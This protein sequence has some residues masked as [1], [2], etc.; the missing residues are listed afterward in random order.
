MFK[1]LIIDDEKSF[2]NLLGLILSE[3]DFT[4]K[5]ANNVGQAFKALNQFRPDIVLLDVK[6]PHNNEGLDFLKKLR[7]IP[8]HR[9]TPVIILSA[10]VQLHEVNAGIE[11]GASL[12]LCKPILIDEVIKHIKRFMPK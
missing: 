5:I 9:Q 7:N 8:E 12:Y 10:K 11:A 4:V 6:L 2:A 1:V 3:Y